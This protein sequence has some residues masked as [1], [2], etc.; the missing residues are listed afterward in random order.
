M[1]EGDGCGKI[2]AWS[3]GPTILLCLGEKALDG[4]VCSSCCDRLSYQTGLVA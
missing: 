1:E 3:L 2:V 4:W